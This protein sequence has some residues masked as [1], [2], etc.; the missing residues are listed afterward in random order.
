MQIFTLMVYIVRLIQ[1]KMQK[2]FLST[3]VYTDTPRAQK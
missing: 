2:A 1:I 3:T